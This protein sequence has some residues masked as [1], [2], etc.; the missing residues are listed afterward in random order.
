MVFCW[1]RYDYNFNKKLF[2]RHKK[3]FLITGNPRY[4]LLKEK[5]SHQFSNKHDYSFKKKKDSYNI[6]SYDPGFKKR[7][8]GKLIFF[9][10]Q[11]F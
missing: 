11:L 2:P 8:N 9:E 5:I 10:K 1:G 7:V 3:K 4:D 6:K